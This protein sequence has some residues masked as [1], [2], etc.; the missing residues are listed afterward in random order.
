MKNVT[1]QEIRNILIERKTFEREFRR[2]E[3][4]RSIEALIGWTGIFGSLYGLS[5]LG[6]IFGA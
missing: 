6:H 3:R 5:I 1:D 4:K 2:E